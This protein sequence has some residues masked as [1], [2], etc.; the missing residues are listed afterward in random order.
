MKKKAFTKIITITILILFIQSASGTSVISSDKIIPLPEGLFSEQPSLTAN[1]AKIRAE[2]LFNVTQKEGNQLNFSKMPTL[3]LALKSIE[4]TERDLE[5]FLK[6]RQYQN[7]TLQNQTIGISIHPIYHELIVEL[8][9]TV[10]FD[11]NANGRLEGNDTVFFVTNDQYKWF[12]PTTENRTKNPETTELAEWLYQNVILGSNLESKL[13]EISKIYY[14]QV[15]DKGEKGTRIIEETNEK[16]YQIVKSK[17]EKGAKL[18]ATEKLQILS[19]LADC[20][21]CLLMGLRSQKIRKFISKSYEKAARERN[22][23]IADRIDKTLGGGEAGM[24][25]IREG[26][27]VQFPSS[28]QV[29]YIA[30]P[31]L[32]ELHR[33]MRE[34]AVR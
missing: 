20:E 4:Y 2:K 28:I 31:S 16:S 21:R 1:E 30:P 9:G 13:G 26:H 27:Q 19:E 8:E 17:L 29:F 22:K 11:F 14:E 3:K 32:D 12:F 15:S 25:F 33:W 18:E 34:Q 5:A 6:L 7:I 23:Y 24:L 10:I